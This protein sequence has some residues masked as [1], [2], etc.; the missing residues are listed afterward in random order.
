MGARFRLRAAHARG[1]QPVLS[2]FS[3]LSP[4]ASFCLPEEGGAPIG[5]NE[6]APS[7]EGAPP[8]A[9]AAGAPSGAP[10]RRFFTRSPCFVAGPEDHILTLSR[11]RLRPAF[12]PIESQ[13]FKAAPSSGADGDHAS[14]DGI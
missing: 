13:P 6:G 4:G 8:A 1:R 3:G 5:A 10:P 14:W 11:Q 7:C 2:F 12:H 9:C